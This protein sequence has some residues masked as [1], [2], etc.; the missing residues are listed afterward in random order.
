[1]NSDNT[2]YLINAYPLLYADDFQFNVGDGWF[3]VIR[4]LS[5]QLNQH[6]ELYGMIQ[7][8]P[9]PIVEQVKE[10]FGALRFYP[11]F[12]SPDMLTLIKLAEEDSAKTCEICGRSGRLHK[13]GW[14]HTLC[15]WHYFGALAESKWKKLKNRF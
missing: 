5:E 13:H 8:I 6:L 14:Y 11:N 12:V 2:E 7:T 4:D 15:W 10:K 9:F 1:M 3:W